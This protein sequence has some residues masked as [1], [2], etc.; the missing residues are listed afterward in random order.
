VCSDSAAG[1]AYNRV[2][3][4]DS[5]RLS[6]HIM[7]EIAAAPCTTDV[8]L[9]R[10]LVHYCRAFLALTALVIL[11]CIRHLRQSEPIPVGIADT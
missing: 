1:E 11:P 3:D 4:R 10:G 5:L 6:S 2:V 9:D 7:M 8:Q